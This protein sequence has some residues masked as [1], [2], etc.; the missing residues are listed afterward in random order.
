MPL[1]GTE[2]YG[3]AGASVDLQAGKPAGT[4]NMIRSSRVA[5]EFDEAYRGDALPGDRGS[6]VRGRQNIVELAN[7]C[8]CCTVADGFLPAVEKPIGRIPPS[9]IVFEIPDLARRRKL[10]GA[11]G[12]LEV[13]PRATAD[14]A[15]PIVDAPDGRFAADEEVIDKRQHVA[16]AN[17]VPESPHQEFFEDRTGCANPVAAGTALVSQNETS[18]AALLARAEKR[19]AAFILQA[20]GRHSPATAGTAVTNRQ[21][22]H[23]RNGKVPHDH[24]NF[25]NVA[26]MRPS[27]EDI[28]ALSAN[29]AEAAR[30]HAI[31]Q[32][33]GASAPRGRP[34]HPVRREAGAEIDSYFDGPRKGQERSGGYPVSIELKG[35]DRAGIAGRL[36]GRI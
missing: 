12:G 3:K 21:R 19:Q 28:E 1:A 27:A 6:P 8:I 22:H 26:A 14:R 32:T 36:G 5:G 24:G 20:T 18:H 7:G 31:S 2:D 30:H 34:L 33:K 35:L 23:K 10:A 15:A 9:G 13:W 25:E 4:F 11:F 16:A 17:P 29:P